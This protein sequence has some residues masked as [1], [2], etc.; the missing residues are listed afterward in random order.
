VRWGCEVEVFG[1]KIQPGQLIHADKHGFLAVPPED[2][3]ALLE[4]ARFMD[5]N[6][7]GTFIPV[8]RNSAGMP[9]EEILERLDEAGAAFRAAVQRK[10]GQKGE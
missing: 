7:C 6:E 9:T 1:A 4:A 2:E 3:A 5:E 10:F 8:A